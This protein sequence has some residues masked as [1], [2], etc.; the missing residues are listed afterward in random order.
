MEGRITEKGRERETKVFYLIYFPNGHS[1][2]WWVGR[3]YE[4]G[5]LS[6]FHVDAGAHTLGPSF[7]ASAGA[8]A[9]K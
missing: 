1:D 4:L 7:D 8:L 5:I 2:Q 9:G 6:F 3:S